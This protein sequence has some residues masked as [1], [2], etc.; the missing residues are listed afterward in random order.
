MRC[1][2][3]AAAWP[4]T[5]VHCSRLDA[6]QGAPAQVH[7]NALQGRMWMNA[8]RATKVVAEP[9]MPRAAAQAPHSA[10]AR[11]DRRFGRSA[12][13]RGL[14][15]GPAI[16]CASLRAYACGARSRGPGANAGRVSRGMRPRSRRTPPPPLRSFRSATL[17]R[18]YPEPPVAI[19]R[20]CAEA[21]LRTSACWSRHAWQCGSSRL[22]TVVDAARVAG[23]AFGF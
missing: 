5:C 8:R 22:A 19:A 17:R 21:P 2:R 12:L 7:T 9:T 23:V 3:S 13:S 10:A 16:G 14:P 20:T 18:G 6:R 1:P 4:S 11:R 15:R